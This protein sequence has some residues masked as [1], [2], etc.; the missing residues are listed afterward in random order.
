MSGLVMGRAMRVLLLVPILSA[1]SLMGSLAKSAGF[2]NPTV[3]VTG[4]QV[5]DV[6]LSGLEL[7]IY[8]QANNPNPIGLTVE[9][10]EYEVRFDGA[11]IGEGSNRRPVALPARGA[12]SFSVTYE[13]SAQ[14]VLSAGLA[15][16]SGREHRVE[17]HADLG[18]STPIG[19]LPISV[20][21]VE[22][23]SF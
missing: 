18:I 12:S 16:L 11:R 4:V 19:V 5:L 7:G 2:S 17:I 22:R 1:C 13:L 23:V 10:L 8:F 20:G 15:A 9:T 3:E 14:E 21:H 6:G